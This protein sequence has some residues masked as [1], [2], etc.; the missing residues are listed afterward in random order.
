M[1]QQSVGGW[2]TF[3][4][5]KGAG[6]FVYK[7]RSRTT[8]PELGCSA[9]SL[10]ELYKPVCVS[11]GVGS[12]SLRV[13]SRTLRLMQSTKNWFAGASGGQEMAQLLGP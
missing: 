13:E 6:F 12:N 7:S 10:G 8:F 5:R 1:E 9:E 4:K 11:L 2:K 3:M